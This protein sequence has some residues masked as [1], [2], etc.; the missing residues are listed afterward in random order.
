[1]AQQIF[2]SRS[3]HQKFSLCR[4]KFIRSATLIDVRNVIKTNGALC[5]LRCFKRWVHLLF[6]GGGVAVNEQK[7]ATSG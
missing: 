5:V 1:M 3:A 4:W 7:I 2:H 6:F